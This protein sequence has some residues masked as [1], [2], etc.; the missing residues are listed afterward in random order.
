MT[1][2]KVSVPSGN[3]PEASMVT[4]CNRVGTSE[5]MPAIFA[6]CCA[7]STKTSVAPTLLRMNAAW[8]GS[9]CG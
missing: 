8:F 3:L 6:A 9:D 5:R 2:S 1:S 7:F 4:T